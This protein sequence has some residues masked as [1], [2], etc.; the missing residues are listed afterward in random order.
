MTPIYLWPIISITA[1]LRRYG[2]DAYG[3]PIGNDDTW[4]WKVYVVTPIFLWPGIWKTARVT[5]LVPMDHQQE[6]WDSNGHVT[7][8]IDFTW[9]RKAKVTPQH[10]CGP[11]SR[12]RLEIRTWCQWSTYRKWLP[13]SQLVT[14]S[15][16]K[17]QGNV[18]P[19]MY[20]PGI[21]KTREDTDLVPMGHQ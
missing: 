16:V 2:V 17:G 3:A 9:P 14:W 21:S 11:L 4:P 6:N 15:K 12:K 10:I 8:D 13:E 18:T 7:D 5:D 19:N 1:G 20:G